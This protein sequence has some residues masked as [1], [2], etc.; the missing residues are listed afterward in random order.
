MA[1]ERH[2]EKRLSDRG[3]TDAS[4]LQLHR[5]LAAVRRIGEALFDSLDLAEVIETALRNALDAVNAES[6]SILLVDADRRHLVFHYSIGE[7][8][9]PPGASIRVDQG[10]AGAV[11]QSG[12]PAVFPDVKL[13]DQHCGD[14][15]ALMGS[16]TRDMITLPLKRWKGEA[17]GVLNVLNK[18]QGLLG[19]HDLHLLTIISAFAASAIQRTRLLEEAK[20]AEVVRL[21]GSISHDLKNLLQPILSGTELLKDEIGQIFRTAATSHTGK[22]NASEAFCDEIMS[23]IAKTTER[24]HDR[25]KEIADCIK[26]L[27]APPQ[28]GPCRVGNAVADVVETLQILMKEKDIVYEALG[29]DVLPMIIADERRLYSAF[30]NLIQNAIRE[31]PKGGF[32]RVHGATDRGADTVFVTVSDTGK[33]MPADVR[34]RLFTPYGYSRK[35]GGSGLGTKIVKDVMDAHNGRISVTSEEGQ[36]TSF[37]L[38][39]PVDPTR[40]RT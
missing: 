8:P 9:I 7:D 29:L 15:D 34:D 12:K 27:A 13:S 30:Y 28:F 11:F 20:R 31:V 39:F 3:Q 26:G 6:G 1:A 24:I 21:L 35:P 17:I 22:M 19:E 10:I 5:D 18:R 4:V 37:Y 33:G 32:I 23:M 2:S 14:I 25:V 38:H 36:G 16:R 40:V